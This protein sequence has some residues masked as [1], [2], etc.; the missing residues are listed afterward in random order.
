MRLT[1]LHNS[2]TAYFL[3]FKYSRQFYRRIDERCWTSKQEE[4]QQARMWLMIYILTNDAVNEA[5]EEVRLC[6]STCLYHHSIHRV[7]HART[8]AIDT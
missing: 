4:T 8:L 1:Q 3:N 6:A 5:E 2:Q 7:T